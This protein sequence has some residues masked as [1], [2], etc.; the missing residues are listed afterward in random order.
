[1]NGIAVALAAMVSVLPY[2]SY[3]Q[4]PATEAYPW[5][6][7]GDWT[8]WSLVPQDIRVN[9]YEAGW[10]LNFWS[11]EQRLPLEPLSLASFLSGPTGGLRWT[12]SLVVTE[13]FTDNVFLQSKGYEK[14]DVW[15]AI[16]PGLRLDIKRPN[17]YAFVDYV[18]EADI[19]YR[20]SQLDSVDHDFKTEIVGRPTERTSWRAAN[21]FSTNTVLAR[22]PEEENAFYYDDSSS[23]SLLV[24]Y[25]SK[26]SQSFS[27]YNDVAWFPDQEFRSASQDTVT[28]ETRPDYLLFP[29]MTVFYD[30]GLDL[31]YTLLTPASFVQNR[32]SA[33]LAWIPPG[34][35]R[36]SDEGLT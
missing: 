22:S 20:F 26:L 16:S 29:K 25:G 27:V 28:W 12:P 5:P 18:A 36:G 24:H 35:L 2:L 23:L 6:R 15:S 21:E 19:Y 34:K 11:R 30:Y 17:Y 9:R 8:E 33:G 13:G 32:M 3:G 4:S 10:G 31:Q 7:I 14:P 1:M